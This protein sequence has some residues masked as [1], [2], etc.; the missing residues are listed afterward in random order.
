MKLSRRRRLVLLAAISML[1]GTMVA[2]AA[3]L[4]TQTF[5]GQTFATPSINEGTC[6]S[7]L[8]VFT[9][10]SNI[11]PVGGN[12]ATIAYA[13][14]PS[15]SPYAFSQNAPSVTV[16]PT[17]TVPSGWTLGVGAAATPCASPT[18]LTSGSPVTL[19]GVPA[20]A[21]NYCLS[22]TSATTFT[23][24]TITWSS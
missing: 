6:T 4:F 7:G 10:A 23:S 2:Y 5:P 17:F 3:T 16:T 22:T 18:T 8:V 9:S 14:D 15:G 24:F 20:G 12:P 11:P 21:W 19:G 1:S 13:C